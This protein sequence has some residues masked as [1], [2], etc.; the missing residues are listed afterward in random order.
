MAGVIPG[1]PLHACSVW[2]FQADPILRAGGPPAGGPA[3]RSADEAEED[4]LE[5]PGRM[6]DFRIVLASLACLGHENYI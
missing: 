6:A 5:P 1:S 3:D 4:L 2:G